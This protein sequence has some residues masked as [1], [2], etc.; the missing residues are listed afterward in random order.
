MHSLVDAFVA[1]PHLG[2]VG[3]AQPEMT[4]DLLRAP[5]LS[6]Q[7]ADHGAELAVRVHSAPMLTCSPHGG[8][9]MGDA[10]APSSPDATMPTQPP[11]SRE[12]LRSSLETT[13]LGSQSETH[14]P[15]VER[16]TAATSAEDLQV[17]AP[18]PWRG[19]HSAR[20]A[21]RPDHVW[22]LDYQHDLT[23]DGLQL[24]FCNVID[25]FTR[26]ALAT[27]PRRSWN[28]DQTTDYSDGLILTTGRKPEHIRMANGPELTSHAL[29]DWARFGAVGT[30]LIGS[31]APWENGHLRML[32]RALS[33]RIPDHRNLR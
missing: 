4:A 25:E 14:A 27:R 30:V 2:V 12:V 28:A 24:R 22:A 7:L 29:A 15:I 3:E 1:Q 20:A 9:A 33:R 6:K 10:L 31:G 11:E 19:G 23:V 13:R 26:E 16:R 32:Q 5:P 17:H 8:A 18:G 21:A